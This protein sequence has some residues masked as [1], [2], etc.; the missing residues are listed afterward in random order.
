[1]RT[2][3]GL[4]DLVD[5]YPLPLVII[6]RY[7]DNVYILVCGVH[8]TEYPVLRCAISAFLSVLYGIKLQWGPNGAVAIWGIGT[9][10]FGGSFGLRK[11]RA[12]TD[13]AA[14]RAEWERWLDV[15]ST[16]SKQTWRSMFPSLLINSVWFSTSEVELKANLQSLMWGMGVKGYPPVWWRGQLLRLHRDNDLQ[17]VVDFKELFARLKQGREAAILPSGV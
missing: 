5:G 8:E 1:M 17:Q 7:R 2:Y 13:L 9:V 15:G 4:R 14:K 16:N 6:S 10:T 3:Q 11:K 12:V